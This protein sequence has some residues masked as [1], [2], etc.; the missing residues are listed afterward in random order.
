MFFY[1]SSVATKMVHAYCR[2]LGGKKDKH[3]YEH[4]NCTFSWLSISLSLFLEIFLLERFSNT[5][6]QR[7]GKMGLPKSFTH[8][9]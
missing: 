4:E 5:H 6:K 1:T 7:R 8:L 2:I 3:K 9:L